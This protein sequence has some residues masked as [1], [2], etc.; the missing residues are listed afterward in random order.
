MIVAYKSQKHDLPPQHARTANDI[1]DSLSLGFDMK[2]KQVI[3]HHYRIKLIPSDT[4]LAPVVRS[5][6]GLFT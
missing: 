2:S 3:K 5:N 1:A 4:L 6:H